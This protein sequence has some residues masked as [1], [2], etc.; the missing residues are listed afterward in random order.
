VTEITWT[1]PFCTEG[2]NCFRLGIDDD[3]NAY[4][5]RSDTG[6]YIS[7]SVAALRAFI[8]AVKN[9]EADHLL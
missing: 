4:I 7:D 9:G 2:S 8:G 1:E 6:E 5:G 3:G